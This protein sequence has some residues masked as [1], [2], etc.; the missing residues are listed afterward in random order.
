M[1]MIFDCSFCGKMK[2]VEKISEKYV[3]EECFEKICLN[4]AAL[5]GYQ[6]WIKSL[7]FQDKYENNIDRIVKVKIKEIIYKFKEMQIQKEKLLE[8]LKHEMK[9]RLQFYRKDEIFVALLAI[10]ESIR[11]SLIMKNN[12][13]DWLWL[14]I[15]DAST[16]N[17]LMKL[18]SEICDF[19]NH[20][21]CELENGCSNFVNMIFFARR[22]NM[23]IENISLMQGKDV[24]L[25]DICFEPIQTDETEKYFEIY[26]KNGLDEKPEDYK[27]QNEVLLKRL[28]DENK[29]PNKIL[30][31]LNNLLNIEF[32]FTREKYQ[33]LSVGLLKMEFPKEK[34][35]CEFVDG[36]KEL[37]EAYPVFVMEKTLLQSICGEETI[38]ALLNIF[39]INRNIVN[40][41]EADELELFCFYEVGEFVVFG[42]FDLSQTISM[43][44]K[45][46]ISGH[47]IDIYKENI[48]QNKEIKK[49]QNT[50]SKYFSASVADYLL[51]CGYDLPTE[52]YLGIEIPRAEIEKI[53]VRGKNILIS[54][55]N[56]KLGDID[57]L[58]L[59]QEKKE[60]LIFELKFYKPAISMNDMLFRDR[61]LV[62]SKNVFRHIKEREEAVRQNVDEV[63]NFILGERKMGYTVKSILLTAR[64][65]YYGIQEKKVDYLTWTQFLEKA[66]RKEI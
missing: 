4:M 15:S 17:L 43:F 38:E 29:T 62:E 39:S 45:F 7:D 12:N 18:T 40:H 44:E 6:W 8:D 10:K 56:E 26:L 51:G 60:V 9:I 37:F 13:P 11:R 66:K 61:S 42:N 27:I 46:L 20:S 25:E 35:F 48:S 58:A 3:C 19:E 55:H 64:A 2:E 65:N 24:Q 57:V 47:Y 1:K 34:D 52:I 30:D 21:I 14:V 32:G 16:V 50:L 63:V 31:R 53:D 22:Y 49:A 36:K 28:E 59:N 54:E 41:I 33:L 5:Y 23:I